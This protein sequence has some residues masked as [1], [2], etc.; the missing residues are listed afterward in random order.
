[1]GLGFSTVKTNAFADF[2]TLSRP[3]NGD[4]RDMVQRY[5]DRGYG[6]FVQRVAE[7]RKMNYPEVEQIA[8]GRVWTGEQAVRNGLVDKIG[9]LKNAI[10][11]AHRMAGIKSLSECRIEEYPA[12]R[13]WWESIVEKEKNDYFSS[14]MQQFLGEYYSQVMTLVNVEKQDRI[15]ARLP[16]YITIK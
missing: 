7:G 15:Q 16:Y 9:G 2:G 8:Q 14:E 12:K 5:V 6:E 3:M 13:A 4:E 11:E 1:M 10:R